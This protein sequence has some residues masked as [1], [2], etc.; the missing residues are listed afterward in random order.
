MF[1]LTS[2][3]DEGL[4]GEGHGKEEEG[5][6]NS[7]KNFDALD[8]DAILSFFHVLVEFDRIRNK[9]K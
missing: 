5:L 4:A 8:G 3:G 2:L 6:R 1:N 9:S 7:I